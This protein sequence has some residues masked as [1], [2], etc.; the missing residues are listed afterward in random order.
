MRTSCLKT[1]SFS[2]PK[3]F[4]SNNSL[5]MEAADSVWDSGSITAARLP[6]YHH[7]HHHLLI[8]FLFEGAMCSLC[9]TFML[10][11]QV[12]LLLPTFSLISLAA[13]APA[14]NF[15]TLAKCLSQQAALNVT[16]RSSPS[17]NP[18]LYSSLQNLRFTEADILT[19]EL[20]V[21]PSSS[22]EV[23]HTLLCC[24]KA[25]FQVRV[26]SGGH[27]YEGLSSRAIS[28]FVIIDL[29]ALSS[30]S[31]D[32]ASKTA[33]AEAGATLGDIYYSIARAD[34]ELAFSAGVC[35]T[36]GSG[37]HFSGGGYGFLSR[38]YGT[39]A[40]NVLDARLIDA[41]G[42]LLDRAAMGEDV[43][44]ALRGGGGGT[45]GIVVAWKLRLVAVPKRVT[46]FR[47]PQTGKRTIADLVYKWQAVA[48]K[49][50]PELFH[51]VYMA[52]FLASGNKTDVE[53][54]FYG[55]YW[56]TLEET[57]SL[58]GK[59]Y[60][61]LNLSSEY[62]K[63]G[64]WIEGVVN[65]AGLPSVEDLKSRD[66]RDKGYFKAKSDYVRVPISKQGIMGALS[67]LQNNPGHGYMIFEPYG[68]VMDS[69]KPDAIAFPHRAGNLYNIQYQAVWQENAQGD[70]DDT[71]IQ[72]IRDLY[73]YMTRFV[74]HSPRAAY[75]N[76]IDLDL[77][78]ASLSSKA[79]SSWGENYFLS[80]FPRLAHIKA[81]FDPF[82][83]FNH[84]Q[85]IPPS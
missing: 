61:E 41:S 71:F 74:S 72:W 37:G 2:C 11:M 4:R 84:P 17:Y 81:Q 66:N 25:N 26:R 18:L 80:N 51:A 47:M 42:R 6:R 31:V 59:I 30:V 54:S 68:G 35:P 15:P 70:G 16:S 10:L 67:R 28:P 52:G 55:Q 40:D 43:F 64:R 82:N 46:T 79:E 34:T 56:G 39:S 53:G 12:L 7:H 83:V 23:Q 14:P 63:E 22:V 13:F 57:L 20:L 65:I 5:C 85:S 33:W 29:A 77:G 73:A 8:F 21:F 3:G 1:G 62:C 45:W 44:W 36:V 27:S 19:P 58:M 49:A 9:L 32:V 38:K 78:T 24:R 69:I 50:P 75:I 76:Y 48:P 60:P